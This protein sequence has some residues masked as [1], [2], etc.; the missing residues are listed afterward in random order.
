VIQVEE[1]RRRTRTSP[2]D[3]W[4]RDTGGSLMRRMTSPVRETARRVWEKTVLALMTVALVAAGAVF[5]LIGAVELLKELRLPH[6]LAYGLLGTAG[7]L[8][9]FLLWRA[10]L[11][12]K[13]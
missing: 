13:A 7:A 2:L 3:T 12:G 4:L 6:W 9:G 10:A 1:R 8:A 5:M 11:G